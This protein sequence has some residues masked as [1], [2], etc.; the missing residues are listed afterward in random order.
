MSFIAVS[1]IPAATAVTFPIV[2]A[3]AAPAAPVLMVAT[4]GFGVVFQ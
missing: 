3:T 4:G 1:V 2:V